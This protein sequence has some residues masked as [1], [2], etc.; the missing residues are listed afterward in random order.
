[1][2]EQAR[3]IEYN[4]S[5]A[6]GGETYTITLFSPT[7]AV[8]LATKLSKLVLEPLSVM[9]GASGN[10][11]NP[12]QNKVVELL[13]QAIRSLT[14]RLDEDEVL[15]LIRELMTSVSKN[16]KQIQFDLEFTGRLGDMVKLVYKIIEVQFEDFIIALG[17]ML[18]GGNES[19]TLE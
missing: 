15:D 5:F 16:K 4:K 17:E 9:A 8:K 7:R 14:Q 10:K 19:M 11:N 3:G 1:M 13:P 12:D 18:Q 2:S 6:I